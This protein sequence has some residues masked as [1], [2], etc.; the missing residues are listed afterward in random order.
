M[1]LDFQIF[2]CLCWPSLPYSN[3]PPKK[4]F[5]TDHSSGLVKMQPQLHWHN[6]GGSDIWGGCKGNSKARPAVSPP[7]PVSLGIQTSV[8]TSWF[9]NDSA[10]LHTLSKIKLLKGSRWMQRSSQ[11]DHIWGLECQNPPACCTHGAFPPHAVGQ[12]GSC[13]VFT[14]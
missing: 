4:M 3:S 6:R 7:V 12:A 14:I 2:R 11:L 10:T 13:F 1:Q 8:P 5:H 9:G